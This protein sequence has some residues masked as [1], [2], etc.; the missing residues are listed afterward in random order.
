MRL[1]EI[2]KRLAQLKSESEKAEVTTGELAKINIEVKSLTDEMERLMSNPPVGGEAE[3]NAAILAE[4]QRATDITNLCRD[5]EVNPDAYIKDGKSVDEVRAAILDE[6]KKRNK[7]SGG[8]GVGVTVTKDEMDKFRAAATDAIL[9]K[10]GIS[11]EKPA[12]GATELRSASLVDFARQCLIRAGMTAEANSMNKEALVRAALTPSAQFSGILDNTVNKSMQTAYTAQATTYQFWTSVGSN[13]DFK[14]TSR[15]Q[16]SEGGDLLKIN[17]NGEFVDD[18]MTDSGISTQLVTYG[19]KFGLSR[20]AIINDDLS[21]I[22]KMPQAYARAAKRGINKAVYAILNDNSVIY[23]GKALFHADHTNALLSAG[24]APSVVEIDKLQQKMMKQTNLRGKEKLN[25]RPKFIIVPVE[26]DVTTRQL[27]TS[28]NDP[29]NATGVLVPNPFNGRFEVISDA[30]LTG[31]KK[32]FMAADPNA[33]DT[34]EVTYLNGS[35]M[36][37]LESQVAWDTLGM[38][39]RIYIDY[40]INV[41]DYRGLLYDK[42]EN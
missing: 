11:V 34:I 23:D 42:G 25:I 2:K 37:T 8:T 3:K 13:P 24:A 41:I 32:W 30:E 7:P 26:L 15:Y 6:M 36:P 10:G 39:W 18:K 19:R 21:Y 29:A 33:I 31:A 17:E 40:G 20:Q 5:F 28:V 27:T 9:L 1:E 35:D 16:I 4:R 14:A 22:T 12:E 38:E